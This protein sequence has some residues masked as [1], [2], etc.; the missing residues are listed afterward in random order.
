MIDHEEISKWKWMV[1]GA[2]GCMNN[3]DFLKFSKWLYVR[4]VY[5]LSKFMTHT[6]NLKNT[7]LIDLQ[8]SPP[9]ASTVRCRHDVL[10]KSHAFCTTIDLQLNFYHPLCYNSRAQCLLLQCL[11]TTSAL[12]AGAHS[13]FMVSSFKCERKIVA[14]T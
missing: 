5:Y 4:C 1:L 13:Y 14:M 6:S 2:L 9:K 11:H 3:A 8:S 10:V 12:L 7:I